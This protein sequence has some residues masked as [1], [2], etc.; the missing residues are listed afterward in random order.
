LN[1]SPR[2][3]INDT[4]SSFLTRFFPMPKKKVIFTGVEELE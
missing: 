3:P 2:T 1:G 4:N